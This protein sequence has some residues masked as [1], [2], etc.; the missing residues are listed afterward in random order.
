M[1]CRGFLSVRERKRKGRAP[2][3]AAPGGDPRGA[4]NFEATPAVA[5]RAP[6]EARGGDN[7]AGLAAWVWAPLPPPTASGGGRGRK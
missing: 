2:S 5:T 3:K 1:G 6:L 4:Q 7:G